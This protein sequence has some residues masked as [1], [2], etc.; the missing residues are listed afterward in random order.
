MVELH[1]VSVTQDEH[2]VIRSVNLSIMPGEFIYLIGKTGSGKSSL[3]RALYADLPLASGRGMVCGHDLSTIH[4]K[5]VHILRRDL[6]IVFQDFSLLH[7]RSAE[8]NLA[9]VLRATGWSETTAIHQR[10]QTCLEAVGLGTKGY[11]IPSVVSGSRLPSLM[12]AHAMKPEA[13]C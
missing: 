4:R 13:G 1:D 2:V 12:Q 6:G 3:L 11:K 10:I 9:F 7:D 8:E 5:N